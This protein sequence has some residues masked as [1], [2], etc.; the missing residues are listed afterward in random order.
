MTRAA[1][2]PHRKMPSRLTARV[3]RRSAGLVSM[4]DCILEMPA[5]ETHTS[6]PPCSAPTCCATRVDESGSVTSRYLAPPPN[7]AAVSRAVSR[8]RSVA[9]TKKPRP[10]SSVAIARPMPDPAPV[11]TAIEFSLLF[12]VRCSLGRAGGRWG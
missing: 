9:T 12:T 6:I 3:C 11:T 10:A 8:S 1:A 4:N 7:F 5:L 2:W